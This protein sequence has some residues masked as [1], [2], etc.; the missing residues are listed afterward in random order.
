MFN[1]NSSPDAGVDGFTS[2]RVYQD[3][4]K[5]SEAGKKIFKQTGKWLALFAA[6]VLIC[7]G[8]VACATRLVY[9]IA[10]VGQDASGRSAPAGPESGPAKWLYKKDVQTILG[11]SQW[12]D[13]SRKLQPVYNG[14]DKYY[15]VHSLDPDLQGYIEDKLYTRTSR[16][17][18]IVV[19]DPDT[20]KILAMVHLD[21]TDP[22]NN[23]CVNSTFPAASVFKIVSAAAAIEIQ[24]FSAAKKFPYNG[25]SHTL[26]KSQLKN[27]TNRYTNWVTFKGAF[28]KS[29]NPV[30][31]KIGTYHLKKDGLT[32]YA[33]AFGFNQDID[34]EIPLVP[35]E[36]VVKDEPYHWAEVASGFNQQ[37]VLTPVHG[38]VIAGAVINGGILIEPTIIERMMDASA[39]VIYEG[40]TTYMRQVIAPQ[41]AETLQQMMNATIRYGTSRKSFRGYSRDKVLSKLD[42]GGK[43]GSMDNKTHDV[44]FDWFVGYASEKEGGQKIAVSVIVAHDKY[45]GTKSSRYARLIMKYYFQNLFE[46]RKA[47]ASLQKRPVNDSRSNS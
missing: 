14:E 45:I 17:I 44:R 2:W 24:D 6:V 11:N 4:V 7:Y 31:G 22:K 26:Y 10:P 19:S 15:I 25:R 41:T 20:G 39:R 46:Q 28:A 38:A 9:L 30:F 18:G 3:R 36:A 47:S 8:I 12:H 32:E 1:K 27:K 5:R 35:S 43:T 33:A 23:P 29:V 16:Y 40:R 37:T 21:K 13:F 34:F 42:I